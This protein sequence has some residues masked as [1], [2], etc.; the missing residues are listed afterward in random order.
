[1]FRENNSSTS[2]KRRRLRNELDFIHNLSQNNSSYSPIVQDPPHL[3]LMYHTNLI[4][5]IAFHLKTMTSI[6]SNNST[7]CIISDETNVNSE[8]HDFELFP[9]DKSNDESDSS[10]DE[11]DV[12]SREEPPITHALIKWQLNIM[13]QIIALTAFLKF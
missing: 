3:M 7:I 4:I 6:C 2:T 12:C 13:Y 10:N 1:M 5:L 11:N 8:H 9:S